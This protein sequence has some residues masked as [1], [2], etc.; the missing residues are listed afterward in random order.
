MATVVGIPVE[1]TDFGRSWVSMTQ[2]RAEVTVKDQKL[3]VIKEDYGDWTEWVTYSEEP[4]SRGRHGVA[5]D[6]FDLLGLSLEAQDTFVDQLAELM[7]GTAD[8]YENTL[9]VAR[10]AAEAA[11]VTWANGQEVTA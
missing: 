11:A 2:Y 4:D 1:V 6:W 9:N 10:E 7:D 3:I 8:A 5:V